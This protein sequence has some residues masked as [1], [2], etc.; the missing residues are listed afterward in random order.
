MAEFKAARGKRAL[1]GIGALALAAAGLL[2]GSTA[3]LA[4]TPEG[5]NFG[6]IDENASG[7]I[8][9]H[10]HEHQNGTDATQNPDGSGATIP[11][12]GVAGVEFTAYP[13]S[14]INL[15]NAA[16]WDLLNDL[17]GQL[18]SACSIPGQSLGAPIVSGLTNDAGFTSIDV[19]T[20]GAYLICETD[21]PDNVVDRALPFVVTIPFP[22][23]NGWLYEVNVYP[24]NGLTGIEKTIEAQEGL[25][26]GALVKFPVTVTVPLTQGSDLL[27][28]F[29]IEDVLDPRLANGGVES[30]TINGDT[31]SSDYYTVETSGQNIQ[32]VF[33][34]DG[35]AWLKGQG[36]QQIKVVFLGTVDE[37]GDGEITN[38]ATLYANTPNNDFDLGSNEVQTNWGNAIIKKVD[39]ANPATV[40]EGAV[41]EVYEAANPYATTCAAELT[42]P[43]NRITVGGATEFTSTENGIIEIL[44]LFVSDSEN[45]STNALQRC[46]VLKEIKA[47]AGFVTPEG[48]AALTALTVKT[49]QTAEIDVQITNAQQEVPELPLTGAQGQILMIIGGTAVLLI[50]GGLVVMNRRR[51]AADNS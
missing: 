13:L 26:L 20:I 1:A 48:D 41:F 7:V 21:A 35:L 15:K 31:V 46:Y 29:V 14:D 39:S 10:K 34:S 36:Q 50:A 23:D 33:N 25:G 17:Q 28:K 37:I 42:D 30:V 6:N 18:T 40:L 43:A 9:I 44:G 11:S 19:D 32:V 27:T 45:P 16:D 2:G 22:W 8:N 38:D 4:D 47:P 49:G 12:D 3:A 51:A 5:L 24:K